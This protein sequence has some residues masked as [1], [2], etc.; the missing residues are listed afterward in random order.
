MNAVNKLVKTG[1]KIGSVSS[2]GSICSMSLMLAASLTIVGC[3]SLAVQP[4]ATNQPDVLVA[5]LPD[6]SIRFDTDDQ[7]IAKLWSASEQARIEDN[8]EQAL[9]YLY[10]ALEISPQN[11]LLWSRAAEVQLASSE[12]AMA[13]NFASKSNLFANNNAP[14]LHRNWLIIEHARSLPIC[15][16]LEVHTRKFRSTNTN[17]DQ[18]LLLIW[19]FLEQGGTS[20][21]PL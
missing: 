14:L 15:L 19:R 20:G 1:S 9:E 21:I 5:T 7:R 18:H 2:I 17:A 6:G 8:N 16:A 10:Q 11:S 4:Q 12:A 13:E 3:G